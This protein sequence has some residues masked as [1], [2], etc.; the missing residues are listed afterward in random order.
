MRAFLCF[1]ILEGMAFAQTS[2]PL[3]WSGTNAKD[4][5]SGGVMTAH[6]VVP[7]GGAI[8]GTDKA[9]IVAPALAADITLTLPA[10]TG[11]ITA[12]GPDISLTTE[13]TG[14]LPIANGGSNKAITLASGGLIWGDA[15]SFETSAAGTA[16]DWALSGGTGTPTFSST[17]TTAKVIDGTA[18]AIQLRIQGNGTQTNDLFVVEKDDGTD[19]LEVTNTAGTKIK[20]TTL[21]TS[22]AAGFVGQYLESA[23]A[24]TNV[25]ANNTAASATT[26]TLTAGDWD[27]QYTATIS[28][29]NATFTS[30]FDAEIWISSTTGNSFTGYS[31]AVTGVENKQVVPLGT[32]FV[33]MSTPIVRVQS[34]GTNFIINGASVA[35]TVLQGKMALTNYTSG[36]PQYAALLRC[37]RVF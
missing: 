14:V 35:Q 15:D 1:L 23:T 18:D 17:T 7:E 37:R 6:L 36:N 22:V 5:T 21:G 13:V 12:L 20:G 10:A 4:L 8:T 32:A 3:I 19:L 27:C 16:S 11:T 24:L 34:D 9:T 30:A 33:P 28:A 2:N 25:A 29:N 26:L 31:E